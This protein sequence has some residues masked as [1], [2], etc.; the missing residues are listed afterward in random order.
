VAEKRA[1]DHARGD[2]TIATNRKARHEYEILETV[3]AG[4]VLTGSEIKSVRAARVSLQE[5]FVSIENGEAWL[6]NAHIAPYEWAGYA[7]HEP[8]R[9]RKL[10]LHRREILSLGF[11]TRAKGMTLVP[12][13]LYL[14][15][16]R[17]KLEIGLARG[18]K[19]YD[20]RETLRDRDVKRQVAREMAHRDR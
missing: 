11:D 12:L 10:L 14:K 9:R 4:L 3:E 6:Q 5:A 2:R 17:A 15:N 8:L 13:R 7:G 18:K 20:K 19:L 1:A 16:G